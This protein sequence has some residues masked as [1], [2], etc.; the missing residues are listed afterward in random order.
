M[1]AP[2]HGNP[3]QREVIIMYEPHRLEHHLLQSAYALLV[4]LS[5]SRLP[6]DKPFATTN[7]DTKPNSDQVE[8]TK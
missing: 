3:P 6:S 2:A 4:P 1:P 5:T 8:G 7:Q